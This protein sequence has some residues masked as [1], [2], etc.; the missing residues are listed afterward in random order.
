MRRQR[1]GFPTPAEFVMVWEECESITQ[2]S[3]AL[4][5]RGHGRCTPAVVRR[6]ARSMRE[7]GVRL[8]KI[9]RPWLPAYD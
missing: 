4:V 5:R 8:K 3:V 9:E 1:P 7:M 2:V 6:W